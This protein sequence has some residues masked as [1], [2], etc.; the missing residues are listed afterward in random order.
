MAERKFMKHLG[1]RYK[2]LSGRE[3]AGIIEKTMNDGGAPLTDQQGR[4]LREKFGNSGILGNLDM[5]FIAYSW[6]DEKKSGSFGWRLT[7]PFFYILVLLFYIFVLPIKW[8]LTGYF[9]FKQNEKLGQF[10]VKWYQK[11][12]NERW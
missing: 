9:G 1:D 5:P 2:V 12:Y 10:F 7:I 6:K 3:T 11:I 8:I 4:V